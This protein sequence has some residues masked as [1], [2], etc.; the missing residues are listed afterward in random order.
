MAYNDANAYGWLYQWGRLTDGHQ[1]RTSGT[2]DTCATGDVPGHNNFIKNFSG[3]PYDWRN[4]QNDSLSTIW[5]GV[6]GTSSPCPAGWR[7]P[8]Q[9]EWSSVITALG[10]SGCSSNCL[11]NAANSAL[12]LTAGGGRGHGDGLLTDVGSRGYYWSATI[13][14]VAA[15]RLTF[16]ST[17]VYP[18]GI[19][20]RAVGES[21]RCVKD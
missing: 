14:G 3:T 4:P 10:L 20:L 11:V 21:V 7:V 8:T 16:D 6:N 2:T 18:A 5:G 17:G 13:G 1:I 9:S 19:D 12:K 15:Y